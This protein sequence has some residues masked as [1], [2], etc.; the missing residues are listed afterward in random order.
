MGATEAVAATPICG[1]GLATRCWPLRGL[2]MG[3]AKTPGSLEV[4]RSLNS[5]GTPFKWGTSPIAR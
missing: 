1:K 3:G 2:S 4:V 5:E